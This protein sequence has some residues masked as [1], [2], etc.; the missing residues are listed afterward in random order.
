MQLDR[1]SFLGSVGSI[2]TVTFLEPG[3]PGATRPL[4]ITAYAQTLG[5]QGGTDLS[6]LRDRINKDGEFLL[7]ARYWDSHLRLEIGDRP[8]DLVVERG[9]VSQISAASAPGKWAIRIAGPAPAWAGGFVARGLTVEGDRVSQVVPYR[10]AILR[11][12]A[13]VREANGARNQQATLPNEVSRQFDTAVGRYAYVKIQG[14][15]YRV[16]FEEAGQ[17]IPMVLQ[18]TAGSDGRQWRHLLED[19]EIQKRFRMIAYD[20][21]FHGKSVPPPTVKWWEKE[22]RLTTEL[23]MD[24]VV[25]ISRALKLDRPVYM[26]CSVGGYLAPDLALYRSDD[27]RAVIGIN[28]SIA[29]GQ[30]QSQNPTAKADRQKPISQRANPD[31][32]FH[33]RVNGESIGAA[34]YEITSPEAP[35]SYRRETAWVYSQGGPGVFAGDLYYYGVDH[36]LVGKASQIDTTKTAVYLLSGEYDPS[37][38]PGPRSAEALAKEIRG[39]TYTVI[40]GGSHFAMSDDYPRFRQ[41]LL[42]VLDKIYASRNRQTGA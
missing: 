19:T 26:G 12:I 37:T 14:V 16:Y 41:F 33:P 10:G 11:L 29:G 23:V 20:L 25:A 38:Q 4:G 8:Y 21:P 1:R 30:A 15:Q 5:T 35:D 9:Q 7:K 24:S 13:L 27:F 39:A 34:M 22:Y 3:S 36:D 32:N 6:A 2:V 31:T 17:G 42:P 18:H 40:K 28:A